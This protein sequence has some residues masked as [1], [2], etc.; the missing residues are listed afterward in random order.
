[1]N[2]SVF[3]LGYKE[4]QLVENNLGI[5]NKAIHRG[6]IINENIFG[7]S[8][9]DIFQEGC[10]WLCKAAVT[11]Q[12]DKGVKFETYAFKVIYNGLLTYCRLMCGKQK[13]QCL[14]PLYSN[15]ND[16]SCQLTFEQ[17]SVDDPINDLIAEIDTFQLLNSMKNQYSGTVKLGI[18]AIELK[19]KGYTGKEIAEMYGVK[20]NLVGAWISRAASR[21]KENHIFM[22]YFDEFVENPI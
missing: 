15:E 14:L 3:H 9:D 16:E 21:L 2:K 12:E 22:K 11:Y 10:I 6:I 18:E 4:Q 13:R 8:Y 20:P 5:V 1:M 19:V 7:F 17:F